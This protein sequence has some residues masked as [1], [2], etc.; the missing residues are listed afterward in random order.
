MQSLILRSSGRGPLLFY[1][2]ISLT[3]T[4]FQVRYIQLL[5]FAQRTKANFIYFI[6]PLVFNKQACGVSFFP[7]CALSSKYE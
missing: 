5:N 4:D 1:Y 6:I 3:R 7:Y 2:F